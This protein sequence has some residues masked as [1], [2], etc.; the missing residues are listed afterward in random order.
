[1][2]YIKN[3]KGSMYNDFW[4][5]NKLVNWTV[6]VV[7]NGVDYG[8]IREGE[9]IGPIEFTGTKFEV[10]SFIPQ[11]SCYNDIYK[12]F[13]YLRAEWSAGDN[14]C[15]HRL[16]D[17]VEAKAELIREKRWNITYFNDEWQ[18]EIGYGEPVEVVTE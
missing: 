13:S 9:T 17:E 2:V 11:Y 16:N 5:D 7:I 10:D 4:V 14:Y 18:W 12:D 15:I 1:M 3:T 8:I 6:K